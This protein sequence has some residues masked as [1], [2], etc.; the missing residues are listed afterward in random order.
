MTDP[1][2]TPAASLAIDRLSLHVPA[3]SAADARRLAELVAASLRPGRRCRPRPGASPAS[4]PPSTLPATD[5]RGAGRARRPDRRRRSRGA[6]CGSWASHDLPRRRAG[7]VHADGPD[8]D[9]ERD[10]VPVQPGD[11]DPRVD[12]ARGRAHAGRHGAEQSARREGACPGSR[13]ASRSRWTPP[14]R[15]PTGRASAAIAEVSGVYTPA[16]RARD[17]ACIPAS[18][19]PE[20]TA[21]DGRPPRSARLFG[22]GGG[23]GVKRAVP[24]STMPT[25]LFVWGPGRILPVRVT[26]ADDHRE[27]LRRAAQPHPRRGADRAARADHG[28]APRRR[29]HARAGRAGRLPVLAGAAPGAGRRQPRQLGRVDHRDAPAV[30]RPGRVRTEQPLRRRRHVP[31]TLPGRPHRSP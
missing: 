18:A 4:T 25:V 8:P 2:Q 29:R 28:R 1:A 12:A 24:A 14:T 15:S 27:A 16:R 7:R 13:S 5:G 31:V 9:P 20:R 21:R 17:A 10:R 3:M 23:G 19:T 22:A 26:D 11:D 30:E 6:H